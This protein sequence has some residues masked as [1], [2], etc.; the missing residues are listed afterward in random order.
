MGS[1]WTHN[2][3]AIEVK[4]TDIKQEDIDTSNIVQT[5]LK[6]PSGTLRGC[7]CSDVWSI[8]TSAV[9]FWASFTQMDLLLVLLGTQST[10]VQYTSNQVSGLMTQVSINSEGRR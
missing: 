7:H 6:H 2:E 10:Q 8:E 5:E 9:P 3:G 1:F 4:E